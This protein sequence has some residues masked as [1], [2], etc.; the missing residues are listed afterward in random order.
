MGANSR[1]YVVTSVLGLTLAVF[2]EDGKYRSKPWSL[3][4]FM[5][6]I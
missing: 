6:E 2:A 1:V 3:P 5:G 4:K